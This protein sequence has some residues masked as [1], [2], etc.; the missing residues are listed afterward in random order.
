MARNEPAAVWTVRLPVAVKKE[1]ATFVASI[2][3]LDIASQGD[4]R[5]DAVAMLKEAATLVMEHCLEKGTWMRF[6][7]ERGVTPTRHSVA[8][9]EPP[10]KRTRVPYFEFPVW[11]LPDVERPT[12]SRQP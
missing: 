7:D 3:A 9:P 4:N 11:V 10:K 2:P 6:L 12:P 1:G 5:D 8:I